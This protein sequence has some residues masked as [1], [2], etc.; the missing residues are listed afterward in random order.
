MSRI[1]RFL[2]KIAV[3]FIIIYSLGNIL[4][5]CGIGIWILPLQ[6]YDISLQI[7]QRA[8][9]KIFAFLGIMGFLLLFKKQHPSLQKIEMLLWICAF[10]LIPRWLHL[11]PSV[12]QAYFQNS[13]TI[14]RGFNE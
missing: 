7:T 8:I 13:E 12:N 3:F 2:D 11:I 5:S 1:L 9:N 6:D 4:Q 14:Q 10:L